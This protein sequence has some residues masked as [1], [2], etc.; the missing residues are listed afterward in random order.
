VPIASTASHDLCAALLP[1][2]PGVRGSRIL[3]EPGRVPVVM[4]AWKRIHRLPTTLEMLAVQNPPVTLYVWNNNRLQASRLD[5]LLARSP[6]PAQSFHSRRN[7]GAFGRFYIARDLAERSRLILFI[8][9]DQ[10][11]G[12]SM[13]ADQLESFAPAS[14]AGWWAFNY[15]PGARTYAERDRVET[16]FAAADYLGVGGMV[17]D[18]TVF[19]ESS[20]FRCP[21][22]Y[23]FVDDIWLSYYASHVLGWQLRRSSAEFAFDADNLNMDLTLAATKARMFRYLKRRGWKVASVTS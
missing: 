5:S 22:R 3:I 1:H 9:D 4:C 8:D 23:W 2:R 16:P 19:G 15:R 18:S 21:R 20:L 10:D 11:F 13:A 12:R 6:I 14:L 7:V 17:A